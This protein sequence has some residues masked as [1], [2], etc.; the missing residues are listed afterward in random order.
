MVVYIERKV[1]RNPIQTAMAI[2]TLI[3]A[4]RPGRLD[5]VICEKK[6]LSGRIS[7]RRSRPRI[8]SVTAGVWSDRSHL[9]KKA[10]A[11]SCAPDISCRVD[12]RRSD[13]RRVGKEC[14]ARWSTYR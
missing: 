13:E 7:Y 14:R 2:I 9:M 11:F 12:I 3:K 6:S 4:A 10:D 8:S 1:T 5:E